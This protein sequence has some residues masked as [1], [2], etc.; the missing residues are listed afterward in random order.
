[1][2]R[3]DYSLFD[4]DPPCSQHRGRWRIFPAIIRP[5]SGAAVM[6]KSKLSRQPLVVGPDPRRGARA[7]SPKQR[8]L[9][10]FGSRA[11][12]VV[13]IPRGQFSMGC[14]HRVAGRLLHIVR[15]D[16][17]D[18]K[19]RICSSTMWNKLFDTAV[20]DAKCDEVKRLRLLW[21]TCLPLLLPAAALVHFTVIP[22]EERLLLWTKMKIGKLLLW[23]EV[24]L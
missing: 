12:S 18:S 24:V 17:V 8:P 4:L 20:A 16:K 11:A 23:C 19:H 9:S 5:Q 15:A 22:D 1:M 6:K 10:G 13:V 14:P 7:P 21:L 3:E 2:L